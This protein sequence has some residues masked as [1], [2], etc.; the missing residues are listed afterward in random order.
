[1]KYLGLFIITTIEIIQLAIVLTAASIFLINI[2]NQPFAIFFCF[3]LG[4][5]SLIFAPILGIYRVI[6][7]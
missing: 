1:M 4:L 2:I 3:A 7:R 5:G 6:K